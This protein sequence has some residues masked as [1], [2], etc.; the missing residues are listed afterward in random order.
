MD[1]MIFDC[2]GVLISSERIASACLLEALAE[3]GIKSDLE[4][5]FC[6]FT[7]LG[8]ADS[9][10]LIRDK[11]GYDDYAKIDARVRET[12]FDRF[13]RE[14]T[15]TPGMAML[16]AEFRDVPKCVASNSGLDRLANSL[17]LLTIHDH[18]DGHVYSA[19]QVTR[20]KPAPDLVEFCLARMGVR[21]ERAL[22]IDDSSHG[23][24]AAVAAGVLAIG[25]VDPAD[26]RTGRV[27]ALHAA[28]A[29][30]VATGCEELALIL[31]S[32]VS[33]PAPT[34]TPTAA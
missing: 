26:P 34:P 31:R 30:H 11:W 14:L 19:E 10:A 28:G 21:R 1:L 32:L 20:G 8:Q 18:F 33:A 7:G 12:M 13:Q 4:E 25:F 5:V 9:A 3:V 24:E 15:A 2:D 29:R 17:G 22:M 23:I 6:L 27:A 16:L